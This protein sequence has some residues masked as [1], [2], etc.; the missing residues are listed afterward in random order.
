MASAWRTVD[1]SSSTPP[2]LIKTRFDRNGYDIQLTDLSR[3][4]RETL[5]KK[6]IVQQAVSSGCS[7]DP[8]DGDNYDTFLQYVESALNGEAKT[9]SNLRAGESGKLFLDLSIPLP[10]GLSALGWTVELVQLPDSAVAT[11]LVGPLLF[12]ASS[13]KNQIQQLVDEISSKDHV[14]QKISDKLVGY[15]AIYQVPNSI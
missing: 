10:A 15:Q 2:L 9:T 14:I 4:W 5:S 3:I 11:E 13:L 12:Q 7:F 8:G 1:F 6:E